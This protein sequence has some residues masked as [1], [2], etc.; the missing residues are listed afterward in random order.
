[1]TPPKT[2]DDEP[3]GDRPPAE[4]SEH[5]APED[6][7]AAPPPPQW[8]DGG[9]LPPGAHLLPEPPPLPEFGV[10]EPEPEGR[11][12]ADRTMADFDA[13]GSTQ[14]FHPGSQPSVPP[15][16][17]SFTTSPAPE[18]GAGEGSPR[19]DTT[20]TDLSPFMPTAGGRPG[21]GSGEGG[22]SGTAADDRP[23]TEPEPEP[24]PEEEQ[25]QE[26]HLEEV[27][28]EQ[29]RQGGLPGSGPTPPA[30][31]AGSASA[32]P[33]GPGPAEPG[34]EILSP[35]QLR[36]AGSPVP[37]AGQEESPD[38]AKT[39][40][41]QYAS[42]VPPTQ[43]IPDAKSL[44]ESAGKTAQGNDQA[45]EKEKEKDEQQDQQRT[46]QLSRQPPAAPPAPPAP[47]TP[48]SSEPSASP[49][50]AA[51][52]PFP[53]AQQIP[54][55]PFA[56]PPPP[57]PPASSPPPAPPAP[58]PFP[59]AQQIPDTPVP[60]PTPP[61]PP[62]PPANAASTPPAPPAP[63]AP[64]TPP[65]SE[66]EPFPYAQQIPDTPKPQP[67]QAA[68][69]APP[70]PPQSSAPEPF[71]YAQQI[72]GT[73]QQQAPHQQQPHQQ[74]APHQQQD[75]HDGPVRPVAPPPQI[76]EP[77]RTTPSPKK[78][79]GLKVG[80]KPLLIGVAGLAAAA[81]VAAG[82]FVAVNLLGGD[83]GGGSDGTARLAGS[84]FAIDPNAATD[85]RDQQ[86]T[87]AAA[88]GTTVVAVGAESDGRTRRGQFLVSTDGGRTFKPAEVQGDGAGGLVQGELPRVVAGSAKGWVAIGVKPG[89]GVV[90]TSQNGQTWTRQPDTA[91]Q[92]FGPNTRVRRIAA[93][94]AGFLALGDT[95]RKG[96]FSD[97]EPTIWTSPDGTAWQARSGGAIG[98]PF[99]RG[100]IHLLE[101]AGSGDVLLLEGLHT[102]N[103]GAKKP[104]QGR[105]VFRTTDGGRT[106]T[107]TKVP[108]PKGTRG[109]MIGGG[110]TGFVAI[111]EIQGG[112]KSYG[113]AF[114][115]RDGNSWTRSGRLQ[116]PGYQRTTRIL[117]S[118]Q[119]FAAVVARG[120]D[121]L[122]SRTADG[123]SWQD[124]GSLPV[125]PGRS[126]NGAAL[127][128]GQ[129]VL[130]GSD[131][132]G[133]ELNALLGVYDAGG[134]QLPVDITK[135]PGAVRP[136]HTVTAVTGG[137]DQAVAVGSARGDAA[138]WTTADGKTWTRAQAGQGVLTRPGPQQL[139]G[140]TQ[141][142]AGWLAIG[143]DQIN[144]RRPLVAVSADGR[145]WQT[146]DSAEQFK[147]A[148]NTALATYATAS[149]PAGYV[150]VGEDGLSAATWFSADL[151][152]WERGRSVGRN[153]L[154]AL[155]NSN[156]W[157][158]GV[159][160]AQSG[161]VAVGGLRDPAV[162]GN[163]P[164]ARPAVWTSPDGKAWTLQQLQL[165][166]GVAEGMLTHVAAKG[167]VVVAAGGGTA[168]LF[169]VS[170]DGGRTWK[171]ARPPVPEGASKVQVTALTATPK[172]FVAAG[173]SGEPGST[174]VV[175]WTS[176]D[177]TTW[178]ASK[179]EGT[180]LAGDG[181]QSIGG[182]TS[183][184]DRL[185]GVGR[186][187]DS[188]RDQ[189]VLWDRPVP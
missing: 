173:V 133:G 32:P 186:S 176:A 162:V 112:G 183:F 165:P 22:D 66:P 110:P 104:R 42:E 152:T 127:A 138:I 34:T 27:D 19:A 28:L 75:A 131:N 18:P 56:A 46:Q 174:D 163:A 81:V 181:A 30:P 175:S 177:G 188:T 58:E 157:M 52:E 102:A 111:R 114:T 37:P 124:G 134:T 118:D 97:A 57:T 184:K 80:K 140:V 141:G 161:F 78:G 65:R 86:L 29:F 168:A 120:N 126:L 91:G 17:Q 89:G 39:T 68:H 92:P 77:W 90:W 156:R 1:M 12:V 64:P 130:V 170:T 128:G 95:T 155:P 70:A 8:L 147:P 143:A 54:E 61:A 123:S 164:A 150:I 15:P 116:A 142:R 71:P 109:L 94:D 160:A 43:H 79:K 36:P 178:Q 33:S 49:S 21:G 180:G 44:A 144:P 38:N 96:D 132:G 85:G 187:V 149:G 103:P 47:T 10:D 125:R 169:Y 76:D 189:P 3:G 14:V 135:V 185:L 179:P 105:R 4:S 159:A 13:D 23:T 117:A 99:E 108:V 53:Y 67:Q 40:A 72:P 100:T 11:A 69:Q 153:S 84:V 6:G 59:Y 20:V 2:P 51:P 50:P 25:V 16:P 139:L 48:P 106:W 129:A 171:E 146:G 87:S 24:E 55:T 145:T 136:D 9:Q 158:R 107:E 167:N 83:G 60:A 154:E 82:G 62:A 166:G 101:A 88:A 7:R 31:S 148:K 41:F 98:L 26:V 93:S 172:G 63:P 182:L 5:P 74:Q 151:K 121:T 137:S 45:S 122:V 115:S 73:P 35:E 113:Q 119:G